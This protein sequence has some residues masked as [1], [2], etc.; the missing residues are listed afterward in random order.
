MYEDLQKDP[1]K[2]LDTLK[3]DEIADII[4]KANNA[5]YQTDKPLFTDD[6]YNQIYDYLSYKS[7]DHPILLKVGTI[8][9]GKK[10]K[11]P[12]FMGSLNKIKDEGDTLNKWK[13][14]YKNSYVI[15]DKL[16]GNSAMYM[17][18][19][20]KK[21][22]W[23][24]GNGEYG[25]NLTHFIPYINNLPDIK[26][27]DSVTVRGE[28]IISKADFEK[29]KGLGANPRNI[30]SGYLNNKQP[31]VAI[32]KVAQF[33]AYELIMPIKKPSSGISYMEDLDF[34][35]VWN[36]QIDEDDMNK[37]YLISTFKDR[38]IKSQFAIDG[39]VVMHNSTHPRVA[40]NPKYGFAFK[41]INLQTD[42]TAEVHTV[43]WNI[44]KDKILFPTILF[45]PKKLNGNIYNRV[46]G[47]NAKY[48]VDN[49]IGPGSKINIFLSGDIIPTIRNSTP[50]FSN[51][52]QLPKIDYKWDK[53]G[54][55][56]KKKTSDNNDDDIM[57]KNLEYFFEYF[58]IKSFGPGTIKKLFDAGYK[59][60]K[61]I[62]SITIN[63]ILKI[64]GFQKKSAEK[65]WGNIEK[66][67]NM[68]FDTLPL[69]KASNMFKKV[70]EKKIKIIIDFIPQIITKRY[71]PYDS[72]LT[73]IKSIRQNTADKFISGIEKFWD[74]IDS[75]SIEC[76]G[77]FKDDSKK[78]DK[79]IDKNTI[80]IMDKNFLIEDHCDEWRKNK[81]IH[82]GN[83][84][85]IVGNGAV[86]KLF[87]KKCIDKINEKPLKN[88]N[89]LK[90]L[91]EN[92]K[93]D[94]ID[95][96]S[97]IVKLRDI[98]TIKMT[99]DDVFYF[100]YQQKYYDG[101]ENIFFPDNA[102][103]FFQKNKNYTV[104]EL[105]NSIIQFLDN[106]KMNSKLF[107]SEKVQIEKL[108]LIYDDDSTKIS[109]NNSSIKKRMAKKES[110]Q[111]YSDFYIN[112][113]PLIIIPI[114]N[115]YPNTKFNVKF[116]R[117]R[118]FDYLKKTSIQ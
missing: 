36:R 79:N 62:L 73:S 107:T 90:T 78:N 19:N 27:D 30:I 71:I 68:T 45:F 116:M 96:K 59:S 105:W 77:K 64:K 42:I 91:V 58:P 13:K 103:L 95:L 117:N 56:I 12:Y 87:E 8:L 55:N 48:I 75:N 2:V 38:R 7:P 81:T 4:E 49:K 35:T 16:D 1:I 88:F 76:N 47:Y 24:R 82:P 6:I 89:T 46:S 32:S 39:I 29:I 21:R 86:Y 85:K 101:K 83:G 112:I 102:N 74:F 31:N 99:V 17:V 10:E 28:I 61:S 108:K 18:K 72:E 93:P 11:L 67:K 54:I 60:V 53:A 34:K 70:P 37:E 110:F 25:Q 113:L 92:A 9:K 66:R 3:T 111:M 69:M 51:N 98:N 44:T 43:E 100:I 50:S 33:I 80:K 104:I 109:N 40:T 97:Q 23:S 115:H 63:Q 84:Q 15:S 22:L 94:K 20:G 26:S 41:S 52:P 106:S 14:V 5:Y 118:V 65:L 57:L 114:R